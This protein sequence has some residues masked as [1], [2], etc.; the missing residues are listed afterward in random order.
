MM[1]WEIC[2]ES[3]QVNTDKP[4]VAQSPRTYTVK[5]GLATIQVVAPRGEIARSEVQKLLR[6]HGAEVRYFDLRA[7]LAKEV[8]HVD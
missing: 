7:K 8:H 6:R 4:K 3:A 1:F 5:T 2:E